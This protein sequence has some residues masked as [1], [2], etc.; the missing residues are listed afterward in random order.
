[1]HAMGQPFTWANSGGTCQWRFSGLSFQQKDITQLASISVVLCE[2]ETLGQAS[3]HTS[4]PGLG[5]MRTY[6]ALH[7]W[8]SR[9]GCRSPPQRG[10]VLFYQTPSVPSCASL[11]QAAAVARTRRAELRIR[12]QARVR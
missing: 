7:A 9:F 1:V 5:R 12:A 2:T 8:E 6:S 10:L 11:Q 4:S 3:E